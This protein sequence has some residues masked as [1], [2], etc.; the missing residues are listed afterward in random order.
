LIVRASQHPAIM[1]LM[2]AIVGVRFFGIGR[3][4]LRYA[5]RLVTH[6]AIFEAVT[7][8]RMRLWRALAARGAASRSML[9]GGTALDFLVG[10]ADH[11]R[12]LVPRVLVPP[13]V[14]TLTALS[15]IV[16]IAL[17]HAPAVPLLAVSC[18]LSI[19]VAP[20][21]ALRADRAASSSRASIRSAVIRGFAAM[22]GA[23]AE[24]RANGVDGEVRARVRELDRRSGELGRASAWALG[25]GG[26]IVVAANSVT[27]VLMLLVSAP[28]VAA[29]TLP[30]EV[31]AVLVLLPLALID[32][33]LAVVDAVQQWPTLASALRKIAELGPVSEPLIG[34]QSLDGELESVELRA[35]SAQW[36]ESSTPAFENVT[37]RVGTGDWLVVTGRSGS[38][39]ST[40][41]T[42]LLGYLP[43]ASG[44]Y[45]VNFRDSRT[46]DPVSLRRHVAWC[47]Q[48]SHLFDSTLRANLLLARPHGDAPDDAELR[49]ALD[50]AG[51][52]GFVDRLPNGFDTRIGSE[53][54][55]LSGGERQRVAVARTLLT[56]AEVVLLD[57]PTAHLD[58]ETATELMADLRVALRQQI[59]VLVTHHVEDE[60]PSDT[61]LT[62]G[63]ARPSP[64]PAR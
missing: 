51:L 14:G 54:A 62:L 25:F 24:L 41:L 59:T 61:V 17:L 45:L 36:P 7:G 30:G 15:A 58:R 8:L 57:E 2:V 11:I 28:A 43:P 23:A 9:R 42:V 35:L 63:A 52:R 1:Y 50:R 18:L 44:H 37:A 12:D 34:G 46:I 10:T 26:A 53:G 6:D 40:L 39:K 48:E 64:L 21:I 5:E 60:R 19:V 22:V 33:L 31:V 55:Q 29:G 47:P 27:A 49:S 56:R 3:A 13:I 20:A 4:A 16:A 32:P 38:G